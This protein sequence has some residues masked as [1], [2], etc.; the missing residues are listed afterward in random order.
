ISSMDIIETG[1]RYR[2]YDLKGGNPQD[3][4]FIRRT[5]DGGFDPGTTNEEL[6]D[7]LIARMY[8]L[9]IDNPSAENQCIVIMLKAIRQILNR[10][11]GK[12]VKK[13]NKLYG[14]KKNSGTVQREQ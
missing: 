8:T 2:V 11:V 14:T 3:I 12:S 4:T 7:V 6:V 13:K 1:Y 5:R 9:Q 10:I